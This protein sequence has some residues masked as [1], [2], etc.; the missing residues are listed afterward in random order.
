MNK[1]LPILL[2]FNF[3]LSSS[4][5]GTWLSNWITPSPGIFLWTIIIVLIIGLC[6]IL[7]W[8]VIYFER[9]RDEKN[10]K[11]S[12]QALNKELSLKDWV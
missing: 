10:N 3:L 8:V 6:S 4:E 2:A 5:E 7:V 9:K 11:D 12:N 1:L